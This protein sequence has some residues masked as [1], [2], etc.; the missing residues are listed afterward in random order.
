MNLEML[1]HVTHEY[2]QS[3]M[4]NCNKGTLAPAYCI[5][6]SEIEPQDI[7]YQTYLF[8]NV[9]KSRAFLIKRIKQHT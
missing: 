4:S 6:F 2:K 3:E 9:L 7:R 8:L 5:V 1:C